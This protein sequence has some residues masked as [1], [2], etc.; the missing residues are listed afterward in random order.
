[1]TKTTRCF[2]LLGFAPFLSASAQAPPSWTSLGATASDI[3]VSSTGVVYAVSA[4][5]GN[6]DKPVMKLSGSSWVTQHD[7]AGVRIAVDPQGMPWLVNGAGTL[8]HYTV[9]VTRTG[10]EDIKG[11]MQ[12]TLKWEPASLRALD[13]AVGANGAVWAIGADQA[14]YHLV[15]GAWNSVGGGAQRI[16]VDPAGNA[17]VVNGAGDIWKYMPTGWQQLATGVARD[18]AIAPDGTVF[19]LGTKAVPGGLE[20]LKMTGSTWTPL[21]NVGAVAIAAGPK[22][23]YI[24]QDASAG[25][26]A[27]TTDYGSPAFGATVTP[28]ATGPTLVGTTIS[29][30]SPTIVK[31]PAPTGGSSVTSGTLVLGGSSPV[32]PASATPL[33]VTGLAPAAA[34]AVAG[35]LICPIIVT[36]ARLQRGCAMVGA[37]AVKIGKAPSTDCDNGSFYDPRNNGECWS[38]PSG[39]VRNASPVNSSDACWQP[40]GETLASA[41]K[42]GKFGCQVGYFSDPRNGG[43]CWQCPSGYYRTLDAVTWS[44]ACAQAITG[45]FS[46]A[47]QGAKPVTSCGNGFSD[48]IDGGTCWTCPANYRRT[49]NPVTGTNACALTHETLYSVAT[50]KKGCS[51]LPSKVGYGTPFRDPQNDGECWACPIPLQRSASPVSSTV[52]SG[53]FAACVAGGNTNLLVWQ[54][55]QYPEPGAYRFMEGL[56]PRV[57]ANPQAVDAFLL[58]QAGGDATQKRALWTS[59]INDPSSSAEL[60]ALLL[61]S[62]VTTATSPNPDPV[63]MQSVRL[64]ETYAHDRRAFVAQEAMRMFQAWKDVDAYNQYQAARRSSCLGGLSA[65]VLGEA[66]GD[67]RAYAWSAAVPDSDGVAAVVATASLAGLESSTVGKT[68]NSGVGSFS[69]EYFLPLTESLSHS[70]DKI[71]EV[72]GEMITDASTLSELGQGA[73]V[74][75]GAGVA[76]VGLQLASA[77]IEIAKGVNILIEKDKADREYA[78]FVRES[79]EPVSVKELAE[80]TKDEDKQSLLLYWALATSPYRAGPKLGVGHMTGAELCNSDGWTQGQC[81]KAKTMIAAAAK[82]VGY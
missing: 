60:K 24:A 44:T 22:S 76:F 67:Y 21:P 10:D 27:L 32:I 66:G 45:P 50:Q 33:V 39:Y 35:T 41:T 37:P 8:F 77:G 65:A 5:V 56:L 70:L 49:A 36:G 74:L 48:P 73:L 12:R 40:I 13:V 82:T 71:M 51:M 57:L 79:D 46:F 11:G 69:L 17:W 15:N 1:V 81:A 54:S 58:R 4:G 42:T 61:A 30:T 64:F 52:A 68:L 16:A 7:N 28:I 18:I 80:S 23:L 31:Q 9:T 6:G 38:C 72:G 59:M 26:L 78:D 62:M 55:P 14:T 29:V 19:I 53:M 20:V 34:S 43:E 63:A 47:S 3:A 75:K 25:S 2:V